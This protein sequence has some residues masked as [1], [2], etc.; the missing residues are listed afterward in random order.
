MG[1]VGAEANKLI[2]PHEKLFK[3]LGDD[4]VGATKRLKEFSAPLMEMG[5]RVSEVF[6]PLAA[7][8]AAGSLAG[9][10]EMVHSYAEATEQ[11]QI[12][13]RVAGYTVG[14]YQELSYAAKQTGVDTDK[15]QASVGRLGRNLAAAASGQ[16]KPVLALMDHLHISL[17]GTNGQ[18]L[19]VTQQLPKLAD[20]FMHTKNANLQLLMAQT[21]FGKSGIALIPLLDKGAAGLKAYGAEFDNIGYKLTNQDVQASD[22]FIESWKNMQTSVQGFTDMV[23]AKLAP[24]LTPLIDQFTNLIVANRA[25]IATDITGVAQDAAKAFKHFDLTKTIADVKAFTA[26]LRRAVDELGGFKTVAIGVGA[27]LTLNFMAPLVMMTAQVGMFAAR[28][29]FTAASYTVDFAVMAASTYDLRGALALLDIA[30]EASTVLFAGVV[31]GVGL[32]VLAGYELYKHW[33]QVSK[34]LS[35]TWRFIEFFMVLKP[36]AAG[37]QKI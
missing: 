4:I 37:W 36:K 7:I 34:D 6:G 8:G 31:G 21:L 19:S 30:L 27:A 16:S 33:D 22:K 14:Q 26:P 12:A 20:A 32:A 2:S 10:V 25:W 17:R 9:V 3:H 1:V 23:S 13:A 18:I 24:V 11:L 15:L 35:K 29:A 28:V 5:Q